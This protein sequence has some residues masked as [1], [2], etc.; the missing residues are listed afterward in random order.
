[1]FDTGLLNRLAVGKGIGLVIGIG[2][3]GM[4]PAFMPGADPWLIWAILFW[5]PTIGAVIGF[6]GVLTAHPLGFPMPWFVRGAAIGTWMNFVLV[7]FAHEPMRAFLEVWFGA[8]SWLASP[9]LFVP[10]GA[11]VGLVIDYLATR[12]GGEGPD[13]LRRIVEEEGEDA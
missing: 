11:A 5:Y 1:M 12:Y 9:F 2:G 4:V 8:G 10:E 13:L 3:L 7:L 6:A